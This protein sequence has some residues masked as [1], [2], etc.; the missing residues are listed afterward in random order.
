MEPVAVVI[1]TL[2]EA[3]SIGE[4]IAEIPRD[5]V[6]KIIVVDGGS[7]DGTPENAAAAGGHVIAAGGR[8]YGRACA[9]GI[10]AMPECGIIV[11]MD[12]DGAD[13][14]D[15]MMLLVDP[16]RRGEYDFV[17]ASRA[18][19]E[20]EPGAMSWHQ[21]LA[22]GLAGLGTRLLYG[23]RFTDMCAYRA[24]RRDCL[25]R[26]GMREM[27][28]GWNLEMQMRAARA[29]LHIL[30][31]P[32]PYRRRRG[33]MSKVAGSFRGS[34]RAALRITATFIRVATDSRGDH[35]RAAEPLTTR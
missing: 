10:A 5:L 20:R 24:I 31:V 26:L 32:M 35:L 16:I 14:G 9:A 30:E 18:R 28:Y 21:L 4:V 22:G 7:D 25:E 34:L 17:I 1:P 12:G 2:N 33:G 11:F 23:V 15:L 13:R 8:G 29:G 3:Q 19:G 27:T 6:H